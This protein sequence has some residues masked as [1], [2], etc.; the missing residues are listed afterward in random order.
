MQHFFIL[1]DQIELICFVNEN[2][3]QVE[4]N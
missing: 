1:G 4:M 3:A 2:K